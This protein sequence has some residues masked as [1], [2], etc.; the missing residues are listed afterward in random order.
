[1]A[2]VTQG[3]LAEE[4]AMEPQSSP[5]TSE[6]VKLGNAPSSASEAVDAIWKEWAGEQAPLGWKL[7]AVVLPIKGK[8]MATLCSQR[9][10]GGPLYK[11][12]KTMRSKSTKEIDLPKQAFAM[13]PISD[14]FDRVSNKLYEVLGELKNQ[15]G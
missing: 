9:T 1:M 12:E 3:L 4:H 8:W 5:A 10:S 7:Y 2:D 11:L 15:R 6:L 14:V 13:I